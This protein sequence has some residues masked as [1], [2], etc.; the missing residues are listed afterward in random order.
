MYNYKWLSQANLQLIGRD[1]GTPVFVYS[2]ERLFRNVQRIRQAARAAG[3]EQ[4]IDLYVPFFPNSNPH[5]LRQFR[6]LD[7]GILVQLPAEYEILRQHGHN[8]FIVSTG[9]APNEELQYWANTGHPMFLSSLDEIEFLLRNFRHATVNV[10]LDTLDSGKPGIKTAELQMLEDLLKHHR[11]QLDSFEVYC[12][13]GNTVDNMVG[14]AEHAFMVFQSHFPLTRAI[15][16]GGGF[17]FHYEETD[18]EKKHF[19]WDRY[20]ESLARIARHHKIPRNVRFLFEPARDVLGDVGVLMLRVKRALI[21]HPGANRLLTDGSR[22]LIPSAQYKNRKHNVVFLDA[23]MQEMEGGNAVAALRG[24]GILRNDYVLP[25]EYSVPEDIGPDNHLLVLDVGA[26]CATQHM[27]FLNI[28]PAA[29]VLVDRTGSPHLITS[30]GGKFDRWR[31]V[32]PEARS[33]VTSAGKKPVKRGRGRSAGAGRIQKK[34][35]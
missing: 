27:E 10:R 32:L 4:R 35:A 26:Y 3:I 31:H 17:G 23:A 15:N 28:P 30:H 2:E 7:I 33:L 21:R 22:V 8:K 9:H 12:G 34:N 5:I 18:E 20:L 19:E 25:G 13:S 6:D 11:R 1:V 14:A 24:R 16:F 29:E